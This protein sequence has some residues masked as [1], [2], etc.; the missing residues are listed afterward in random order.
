[1]KRESWLILSKSR[2]SLF[3]AARKWKKQNSREGHYYIHRS[4]CI[5]REKLY[6]W[7]F[8]Y[9]VSSCSFSRNRSR[10]LIFVSFFFFLFSPLFCCCCYYSAHSMEKVIL[11]SSVSFFA[12]LIISFLFF[13]SFLVPPKIKAGDKQSGLGSNGR[14]FNDGS[15]DGAR[16]R[17]SGTGSGSDSFGEADRR[18]GYTPPYEEELDRYTF[19]DNLIAINQ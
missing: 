17:R 14:S 12:L 8:P 18:A 10:E 6:F 2:F 1:M 19:I 11:S 13:V 3:S 15:R 5:E 9:S 4:F 16:D 7:G